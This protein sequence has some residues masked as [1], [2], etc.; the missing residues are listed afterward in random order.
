MR[1]VYC[2]LELVWGIL[3]TAVRRSKP[4]SEK[5][6]RFPCMKKFRITGS[7]RLSNNP[8]ARGTFELIKVSQGLLGLHHLQYSRPSVDKEPKGGIHKW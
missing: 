1:S 2:K 7:V 5:A 4:P 6:Y 8:Y 3:S